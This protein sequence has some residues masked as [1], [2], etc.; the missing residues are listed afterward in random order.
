MLPVGRDSSMISVFSV[1]L[2]GQG[3]GVLH[4]VFMDV[5]VWDVVMLL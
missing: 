2:F 1:W 4:V 5:G 3:V